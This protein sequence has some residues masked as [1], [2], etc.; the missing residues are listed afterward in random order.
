VLYAYVDSVDF[1]EMTFDAALRRFLSLFWL[2]GEAQKIDRMMEKFAER[3]CSQ[4]EGVF[5]NP[6]TAYVLAY[7]LIMLNTGEITD[8]ARCILSSYLYLFTV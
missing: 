2:P 1:A 3:F 5:A 8:L 4:N 6:D 7:S